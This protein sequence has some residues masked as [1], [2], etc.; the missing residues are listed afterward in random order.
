MFSEIHL[1]VLSFQ[2]MS[3]ERFDHF[4]VQLNGK[5]YSAWA[6]QFEILVKGKE[7]WGH[8]DGNI[9]TPDAKEAE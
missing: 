3:I 5:N 4:L 9:Y 1:L 8:M 2:I 6:F 7:L